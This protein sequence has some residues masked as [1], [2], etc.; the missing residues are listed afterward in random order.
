[1]IEIETMN[2]ENEQKRDRLRLIHREAETQIE[3]G[4]KE[5]GPK[6]ES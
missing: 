6:T 3:N 2:K 4:K 5:I 1:M